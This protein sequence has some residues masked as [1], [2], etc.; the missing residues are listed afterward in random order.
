[1]TDVAGG[2]ITLEYALVGL[3]YSIPTYAEGDPLSTRDQDVADYIVSATPVIEKIVRGPVAQVTK[4]KRA[5]GGKAGVP[6][7]HRL[8]DEDAVTL[9]VEDGQTIADYVVDEDARIVFAGTSS[10]PRRFARGRKNIEVTYVT[11][12]DPV[13]QTILLATRDLVV[14]WAQNKQA[15]MPQYDETSD[16][17]NDTVLGFAVPN[18]VRE[19]LAPYRLPGGLA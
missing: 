19:K 16:A 12:W 5:N 4:T 17:D 18:T 1:M 14:F 8:E 6:L 11:G 10:S 9:V 7:P 15:T 2:L 3:G 13:P